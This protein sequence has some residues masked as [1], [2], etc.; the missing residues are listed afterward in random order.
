[1][2]NSIDRNNAL[3]Y[4]GGE[5][6]TILLLNKKN[7]TCF[8]AEHVSWQQIVP[9]LGRDNT[10]VFLWFQMLSSLFLVFLETNFDANHFK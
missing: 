9:P 5:V 7:E 10:V 3:L 6:L 8:M 1:M 4:A 2:Y